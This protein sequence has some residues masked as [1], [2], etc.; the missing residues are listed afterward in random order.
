M[1]GHDRFGA[2]RDRLL[3]LR[4]IDEQLDGIDVDENRDRADPADGLDRRDERV[5]GHDDFVSCGNTGNPQGQLEC[6]GSVGDTDDV[7]NSDVP[8]IGLLEFSDDRAANECRA[9]EHGLNPWCDLFGDLALL[10]DEV[11]QWHPHWFFIRIS[12]LEQL[13]DHSLLL[14]CGHLVIQRQDQRVVGE[15]FRH[16]QGGIAVVAVRVSRMSMRRHDSSSG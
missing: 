6:V 10:C 16:A 11:D 9:V 7:L 1:D 4:W 14:R 15:V 8:C 12:L 5:R 2:G 3:G 13:I